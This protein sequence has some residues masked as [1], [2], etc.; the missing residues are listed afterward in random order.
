MRKDRESPAATRNSR[1][2]ERATRETRILFTRAFE[3]STGDSLHRRRARVSDRR[4][5]ADS[6]V[7]GSFLPR[8]VS[9]SSAPA[10]RLRSALSER[11][12]AAASHRAI[13]RPIT[14]DEKRAAE[15]R[16]QLCKLRQRKI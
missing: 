4:S 10:A 8:L 16:G 14:A 7:G 3:L 5:T 12:Q 2:W 1:H 13:S 15:D 11:P 9:A 6:D